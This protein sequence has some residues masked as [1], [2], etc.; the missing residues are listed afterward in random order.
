M[1][2]KPN[3]LN[4]R[5]DQIIF[6]ATNLFGVTVM[7]GLRSE[8]FVSELLVQRGRIRLRSG[9]DAFTSKLGSTSFAYAERTY[10]LVRKDGTI[11]WNGI[12]K[13]C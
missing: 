5:V 1:T 10:D 7:D 9:G 12:H 13:G 4:V 6:V 2:R 8:C 11:K 3:G